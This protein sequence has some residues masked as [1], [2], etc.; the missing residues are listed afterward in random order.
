MLPDFSS[1]PKSCCFDSLPRSSGDCFF[2][3][4]PGPEYLLVLHAGGVG[5]LDYARIWFK[6]LCPPHGWD[7][8]P[9]NLWLSEWVTGTGTAFHSL[10]SFS[11]SSTPLNPAILFR[12]PVSPQKDQVRPMAAFTSHSSLGRRMAHLFPK[13]ACPQR[14]C[15]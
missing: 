7:R 9:E 13:L 2:F 5:L 6:L 14:L 8:C 4:Y 3:F 15:R 11:L 1:L 10:L 12:P